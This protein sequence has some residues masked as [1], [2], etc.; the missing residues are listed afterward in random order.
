MEINIQRRNRYKVLHGLKKSCKGIKKKEWKQSENPSFF[1][2][3][4]KMK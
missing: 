4:L 3:S 2:F 1:F